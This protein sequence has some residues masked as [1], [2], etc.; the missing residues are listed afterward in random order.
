MANKNN[1][2]MVRNALMACRRS[3]NGDM[4]SAHRVRLDPEIGTRC[5]YKYTRRR[6][7]RAHGVSVVCDSPVARGRG[8]GSATGA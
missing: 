5:S 3:Y 4:H 6:C 8:S 1:A 7:T 2:K